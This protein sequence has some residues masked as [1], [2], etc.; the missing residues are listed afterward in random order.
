M[1]FHSGYALDAD[2]VA[3][4]DLDGA[5]NIINFRANERL[6]SLVYRL[7]NIAKDELIIQTRM[8]EY[9][10]REEIINFNLEKLFDLE[11]KERK[12]LGLPPFSHLAQINLRGKDPERVKKTAFDIYE[13]LM[14]KDR[15]V[16]V[17]E[18]SEAMPLKLRGNYRFRIL[19]KAKNAASISNFLSRHLEKLRRP[20]VITTIEMDPQ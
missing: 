15:K 19:M 13:K 3:A 5:L 17:F 20:M 14:G 9:Y 1:L 6:Y 2:I 7:R 8:P 4:L 16:A 18:P 10:R 11:L 12:A